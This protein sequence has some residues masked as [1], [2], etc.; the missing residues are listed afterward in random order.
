MSKEE[1]VRLSKFTL[2]REIKEEAAAG[3]ETSQEKVMVSI[4]RQVDSLL[5]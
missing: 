5:R 2:G 1:T 3:E 4:S